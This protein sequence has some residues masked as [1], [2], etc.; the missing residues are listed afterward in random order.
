MIEVVAFHTCRKNN[1]TYQA[2]FL[3]RKQNQW[4]TRGYYFWTDSD[5]FAKKW[6]ESHYKNKGDEYCVM[7]FNLS[8]END[9]LLDLVGNVEHKIQFYEKVKRLRKLNIIKQDSLSLKV[10]V[11]YLRDIN[12]ENVGA[13]SYHAIKVEDNRDLDLEEI[14]VMND[15]KECI[16]IGPTRQQLCIF[17]N[18]YNYYNFEKKEEISY[19]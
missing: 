19:E 2:P 6:G 7:K 14:P 12:K 3:S 18:C 11:Q 13:W 10:I 17:E 1:T 16:S 5:Y 15:S 8:F 4:L 9:V